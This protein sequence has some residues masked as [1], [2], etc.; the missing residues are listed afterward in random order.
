MPE[1]PRFPSSALNCWLG[2]FCAAVA[3][4]TL[5]VLPIGLTSKIIASALFAVVP[6]VLVVFWLG[7]TAERRARD[8]DMIR[9]ASR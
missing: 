1:R 6:L 2:L 9:S 3:L 4:I 5:W 7:Q 8:K